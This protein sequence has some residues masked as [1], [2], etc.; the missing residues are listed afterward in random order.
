LLISE[1]PADK[2]MAFLA[3]ATTLTRLNGARSMPVVHGV[4]PLAEAAERNSNIDE[5]RE[6]PL[7]VFGAGSAFVSGHHR[8]SVKVRD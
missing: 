8:S 1:T 3:L 4:E 2:I 6:V 5:V 7:D